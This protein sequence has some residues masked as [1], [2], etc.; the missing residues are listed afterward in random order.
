MNVTTLPPRALRLHR[1]WWV[2]ALEGLADAGAR[3]R[4]H[5]R[6][7][8]RVRREL[9]AAADL[10]EAVLR[11]MG[12][13]EWLVLEASARREARAFDREVL[14]LRARADQVARYY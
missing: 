10:S 9:A 14:H 1:P 2:R 4:E 5:R 8:G 13:P 12:A 7:R 11:D 6:E 3:W